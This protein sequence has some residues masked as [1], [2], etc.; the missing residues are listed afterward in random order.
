[1]AA[2]SEPVSPRRVWLA[3]AAGGGLGGVIVAFGFTAVRGEAWAWIVVGA[4]VI[5]LC[6]LFMVIRANRRRQVAESDDDPVASAARWEAAAELAEGNP[7]PELER[8]ERGWRSMRIVTI[9]GSVALIVIAAVI[10]VIAVVGASRDRDAVSAIAIGAGLLGFAILGLWMY[11]GPNRIRFAWNPAIPLSP[12]EQVAARRQI[13]GRDVVDPDHRLA[14]VGI[15]RFQERSARP[16]PLML[17]SLTLVGVG[18]IFGNLENWV[19]Y[20]ALT[21]VAVLTIG[22]LGGREL[23]IARRFLAANAE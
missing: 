18:L 3:G 5:L 12:A 17:A 2:S 15:A 11:V 9:V 4:A 10:P 21:A 6:A 16:L 7:D 19:P 20:A 14:L 23:V 22:I 8:R 13:T 1:M